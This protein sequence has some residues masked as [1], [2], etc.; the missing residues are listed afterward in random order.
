M[1]HTHLRCCCRT[2]QQFARERALIDQTLCNAKNVAKPLTTRSCHL[3]GRVAGQTMRARA[4]RQKA[5]LWKHRASL[6][7]R[8]RFVNSTHLLLCAVS[9]SAHLVRLLLLQLLLLLLLH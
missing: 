1:T 7:E 5:R 9:L 2:S 6:F 4:R 8:S 3:N